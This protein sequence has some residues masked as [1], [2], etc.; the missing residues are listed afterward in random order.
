MKNKHK[1]QIAKDYLALAVMEPNNID[2]SQPSGTNSLAKSQNFTSSPLESNLKASQEGKAGN[3]DDGSDFY[4]NSNFNKNSDSDMA[5]NYLKKKNYGDNN[6]LS[7]HDKD[8]PYYWKNAFSVFQQRPF[9]RN[10]VL[11]TRITNPQQL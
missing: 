5:D 10:M 8:R 3:P 11:E 9:L 1:I 2:W 6:N 7:K 4:S